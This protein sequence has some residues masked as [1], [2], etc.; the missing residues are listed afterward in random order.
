MNAIILLILKCERS[1]PVCVCVC[2][3][4]KRVSVLFDA[5]AVEGWQCGQMLLYVCVDYAEC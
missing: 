3:V 2:C 1:A 5:M 4:C